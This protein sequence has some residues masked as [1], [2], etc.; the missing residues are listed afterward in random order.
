MTDPQ[1]NAITDTCASRAAGQRKLYPGDN[2]RTTDAK[3][4]ANKGSR[5]LPPPSAVTTIAVGFIAPPPVLSSERAV[6]L[7]IR[8]SC[9][10]V[11]GWVWIPYGVVF[12]CNWRPR[13]QPLSAAVVV[14]VVVLLYFVSPVDSS[15]LT[16]D[17]RRA[18][19]A[20]YHR[21]GTKTTL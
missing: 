2:H 13:H 5:S 6:P 3:S 4:T 10:T 7:Y 19:A 9:A 11:V 21:S 1:Q 20:H 14:V 8:R 16:L 17:R 18:S 12:L 15:S